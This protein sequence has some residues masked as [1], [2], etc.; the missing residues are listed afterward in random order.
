LESQLT[1]ERIVSSKRISELESLKRSV[2]QERD[3]LKNENS[4]LTISLGRTTQV[5]SQET[6]LRLQVEQLKRDLTQ[7]TDQLF[8]EQKEISS[9]KSLLQENISKQ[10]GSQGELMSLRVKVQQLE[11]ERSL[12]SHNQ[13]ELQKVNQKYTKLLGDFEA[14]TDSLKLERQRHE[15]C[16]GKLDKVESNKSE[17]FKSQ[18]YLQQENNELKHKLDKNELL[19]Q[20]LEKELR[21]TQEERGRSSS[22]TEARLKGTIEQ[23]RIE[24]AGKDERISSLTQSF[25]NLTIKLNDRGDYSH[26]DRTPHR[27]D[28]SLVLLK[29]DNDTLKK[30]NNQ[31]VLELNQL[32]VENTSFRGQKQTQGSGWEYH[33]LN[34][35]L[36]FL[37][38][39]LSN[40]KD[41]GKVPAQSREVPAVQ[42]KEQRT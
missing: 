18:G 12:N 19:I 26:R 37:E 38:S 15:E 25:T 41:S 31:L 11:S 40:D 36:L 28:E 30:L 21:K 3:N 9:L 32:R 8:M 23:L 34:T 14:Q 39:R 24:M 22:E 42:S 2:E 27:D 6:S 35:K 17:A 29:E 13:V 1:N 7:K 16:R 5:S 33:E 10:G 20:N 4:R